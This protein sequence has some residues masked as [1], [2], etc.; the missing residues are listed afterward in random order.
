MSRIRFVHAADLHLDSPFTGIRSTAPENVGDALHAATFEAYERI[1]D[2]CISERVDALLIAGDIYDSADRSL[3]AQRSFIEGLE[4]L[5]GAGIR[6]FVCHG[7][8]D[9]LD[10]WEARLAYPPGCH[11]FGGEW[12]SVP[13][14]EDDPSR[15]VTHGVSYPRREVKGNLA[16]RLR[17]VDPGPFSIGLLHAN[18]GGDPNHEPYAP[19]TL[20]DLSKT[21]VDYWALGHVHTPRVLRDQ[22]PT[23]VYPGNS[24]GR[25]PNETGPRGVYLVEIDDSRTANLDFRPVDTV[26]WEL[27]EVDISAMKTEQELLDALHDRI[28]V[29]LDRASGRSIVVRVKLIGRGTL[30]RDVRRDNT[31]DDVVDLLNRDWANQSP[32]AWVERIEDAS[33]S[34]FD[35]AARLAGTDFVAEVLRTAD[36]AKATPEVL[37]QL[38]DGLPELYQHH[39]FRKY[40]RG[41]APDAN[42]VSALI[43]A[44]EATVVNLLVGDDHQ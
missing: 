29:L 34:P 17:E 32:F 15:A 5:H 27:F 31:I 36:L 24:Q 22:G 7:N 39:R 30:S 14:F 37:K 8:H 6:S 2:L 41:Y 19:C 3:R 40:L 12:E 11:R 23:V 13:V 33:A 25:S 9:P 4:R 38:T 28:Q 10:G 35:R 43:E 42:E 1:I 44:A 16:R 26:R 20:N 18:V 21:G